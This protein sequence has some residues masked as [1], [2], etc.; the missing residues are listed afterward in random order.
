MDVLKDLVLCTPDVL[1][2]SQLSYLNMHVL[3]SNHSI[4]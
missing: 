2:L 3:D 1:K 4:G